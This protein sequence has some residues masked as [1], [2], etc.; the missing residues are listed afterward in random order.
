MFS[1][2]LFWTTSSFGCTS[3]RLTGEGHTDF[4]FTFFLRCMPCFSRG[5]FIRSFPSSKFIYDY[6]HVSYGSTAQ[7]LYHPYKRVVTPLKRSARKFF[8]SVSTLQSTAGYVNIPDHKGVKHG[9]SKP[10]KISLLIRPIASG[11]Y[12]Y[13][14]YKFISFS[15]ARL[16]YPKAIDRSRPLLSQVT[17]GRH[18]PIDWSLPLY[19]KDS[20][21]CSHLNGRFYSLGR[22]VSYQTY[23]C[24][25]VCMY[26]LNCT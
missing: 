15:R 12:V 26:L 11:R 18:A 22:Q 8:P 14:L 4:S 2:R 24:M 10:T 25:Y 7:G 16:L 21:A 6:G 13:V 19:Y 5:G 3:W 1:S 9:T 17:P 20:P 23:V